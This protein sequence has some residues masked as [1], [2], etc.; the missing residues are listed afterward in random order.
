MK[1]IDPLQ[2]QCSLLIWA[3][4][5]Y[6]TSPRISG[7]RSEKAC[8]CQSGEVGQD[9]MNHWCDSIRSFLTNET[10]DL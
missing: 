2:K 10:K 3:R 9:V 8:H 5:Q 4:V 1:A 7:G 6:L